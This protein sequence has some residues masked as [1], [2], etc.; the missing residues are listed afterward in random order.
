MPT[1][2]SRSCGSGV[3]PG[4]PPLEKP[5]GSDS[6][7]SRLLEKL[8]RSLNGKVKHQEAVPAEGK[9]DSRV[10]GSLQRKVGAALVM[11]E[12]GKVSLLT[13]GDEFESWI[14]TFLQ[15]DGRPA[16]DVLSVRPIRYMDVRYLSRKMAGV[17]VIEVD[18]MILYVGKARTI[19]DRLTGHFFNVGPGMLLGH[20]LRSLGAIG[21]VD[22]ERRYLLRNAKIRVF[23]FDPLEYY[24]KAGSFEED[25]QRALR[26]TYGNGKLFK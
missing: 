7:T 5:T 26:P 23:S 21:N 19:R 2:S 22:R 12:N 13:P 25:I 10:C 24:R 17:Y 16:G 11:G 8:G 4:R 18:R 15:F 14:P 6:L 20:L 1:R 3:T 9:D